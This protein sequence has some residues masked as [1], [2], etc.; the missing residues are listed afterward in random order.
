MKFESTCQ[1]CILAELSTEDL[2]LFKLT[3]DEIDYSDERV[4]DTLRMILDEASEET[5]VMLNRENE[6]RIDVMPDLIGGCLIIFSKNES[7]ESEMHNGKQIY[8]TDDFN[9]ILDLA[10]MLKKSDFL[11]PDC[12]LYRN[13]DDFRLIVESCN[14]KSRLI[15]GEYLNKIEDEILSEERTK[16]YWSCLIE[17]DALKILCGN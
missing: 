4:R 6:I 8:E 16:E 2:K 9:N 3:Y 14:E 1:N 11:A 12:A 15:L 7:N 13:E 10:V 17:K 5:G